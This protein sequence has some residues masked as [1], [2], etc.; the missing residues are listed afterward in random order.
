MKD[1]VVKVQNAFFSVFYKEG[2]VDMG[3]TLSEAGVGLYSSGGTA[4]ELRAAGLEV[5]DVESYTGYPALFGH[6]V[7]TLHP[8][9]HGGIL[10]RRGHEQD[11]AEAREHG[12]Q[13]ID[14]V[15]VNPYPFGKVV[16]KIENGE[17]KEDGTPYTFDD[18]IEAIDIGGPTLVRGAAKNFA[19]VGA[20]VDPS[21]YD[22]VAR[23]IAAIGG[24][25]LERRRELSIKVFDIMGA[26]NREIADFLENKK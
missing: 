6:R 10:Y 1:D 18:A 20:V 21:D 4:R 12:I 24:L 17:L 23:E 22:S 16:E 7:V 14:L 26:Y 19:Y 5:T 13:S 2:I 8:K 15:V 11:I 3:R 25:T 9:V